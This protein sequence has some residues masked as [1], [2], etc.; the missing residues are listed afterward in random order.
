MRVLL[1][2]IGLNPDTAITDHGQALSWAVANRHDGVVRVFL[3]RSGPYV[4]CSQRGSPSVLSQDEDGRQ[5]VVPS[6]HSL[7]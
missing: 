4:Q 3:E 5:L 1:E 6:G 7:K 2:Q